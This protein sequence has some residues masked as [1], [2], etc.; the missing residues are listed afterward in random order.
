MYNRLKCDI[1]RY[2]FSLIAAL[3]LTVAAYA[4][5]EMSIGKSLFQKALSSSYVDQA[6]EYFCEAFPYLE[7][8]AEGGFGEA[9]YLMAIM[10]KNGYGVE[11]DGEIAQIMFNR[12]FDLGW[13]E[14]FAELGDMYLYGAVLGDG[15]MDSANAFA[16]YVRGTMDG[17]LEERKRCTN[18]VAMCYYNG[19]G[20][21]K[22]EQKAYDKWD[23]EVHYRELPNIMEMIADFYLKGF[24]VKRDVSKAAVIYYET[25]VPRF[26][27]KAVEVMTENNIS[28]VYLSNNSSWSRLAMMEEMM[29]YL[30]MDQA[31]YVCYLYALD[32][33]RA[34]NDGAYRSMTAEYALAAS[35]E[36][37][38]APAQLLLADWYRRGIKLS[39]NFVRAQEWYD[40][41]ASNEEFV[42]SEQLLWVVKTTLLEQQVYEVQWRVTLPEGTIISSLPG[43]KPISL[44]LS[45]LN[46]YVQPRGEMEIVA[47]EVT[48]LEDGTVL[49]GGD[50]VLRQSVRVNHYETYLEGSLNYMLLSGEQQMRTMNQK[51][52]VRFVDV[53]GNWI[54]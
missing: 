2:I 21:E 1:M 54:G 38:Y 15:V 44:E 13:E 18:R 47:S 50:I 36:N 11:C 16:T 49:Y 20:V 29:P 7:I 41:A 10:Y 33:C 39:K 35:A 40:V 4:Q 25:R 3:F 9:C 43:E 45:P 48:E 8:A 34:G 27:L 42:S 23:K 32:R 52:F 14:G 46:G 19:W 53:Q 28:R 22:N 37:G 31:A 26:M 12:G 51:V 5:D 30:D 17:S 6:N 24:N